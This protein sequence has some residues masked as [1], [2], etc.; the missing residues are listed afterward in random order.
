M[1][2][3]Q[4]IRSDLLRLK[5]DV[6]A[7]RFQRAMRRHAIALKAGFSP[8]Q[9][10]DEQGRWTDAGGE[11]EGDEASDETSAEAGI[12]GGAPLDPPPEIPEQRPPTP[13]ETYAFLKTAAQWIARA[14]RVGSP[15]GHFVT[16]YRAASWLDT[17]RAFIESYQDPPRSL[18]ELQDAATSRKWGYHIHHVVE[19]GPAREYGFSEELIDGR[20]NRVRIPALKHVEITTWFQTRNEKFGYQSPRNYLRDKSWDDRARIGREALIDFGVLKP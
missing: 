17:D 5:C 6:A 2:A 3:L 12:E 7:L 19:Q 15:V 18:A 4:R 10:R 13:H 9:P 1:H 8:D 14:A 20:D 16:A 11:G